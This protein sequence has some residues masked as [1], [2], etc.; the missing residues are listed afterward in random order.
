M[1]ATTIALCSALLAAPVAARAQ[2]STASTTPS[3]GAVDVG[4]QF[5]SVSGDE[6]RY[7]H[8]RDL[9]T[10]VL[11]DG[12]HFT[13]EKNDWRFKATAT[14]VGYRD[15]KYTGE[16][17]RAG[18][19]LIT[20]TWDQIPLFYGS[21]D[22]DQFGLL[23]ATP[24][25][26][27]S[28]GVSRLPDSLQAA[29][30]ATPSVLNSA[31]TSAALGVEMR[32]LRKTADFALV[33]HAT[34]STDLLFHLVNTMKDGQQ[35]WAATFGFSNAIELPG[36]LDHRT[37]D[38]TGQVQWS[39]ER[40]TIRAGYDGSFFSNNVQTLVWDN[41]L[42][43]TDISGGPSQGREPLWPDNSTNGVSATTAWKLGKRTRVFGNLSFSKWS[44]DGALLPYT[45]NTALPVFPLERQTA[46]VSADVTGVYAGLNSRPSDRSWLTV[47]YKLYDYDNR[48]PEFPVTDFVNYDTSVAAF[49]EGGTDTL[50]YKRQ[51]FDADY[52]YNIAPFTAL[53]AGYGL[54][55][56]KR[57]FR[58]FE[59]TKDQTFR[60]SLDTTGTTWLMLRA[61]YNYSKRTGTGLD[62]EVF[63][64]ENEGSA[65]PR[66][67]DIADRNRNRVAVIATVTPREQF[68]LNVSTGYVKDEYVN[69]AFGL[70]NQDGRFFSLGADYSPRKHVDVFADY[71]YEKYGT[72]QKS[73]QASPGTQEFDPTRDWTNDGSDHAHT[74]T[75]GV[76]LKR[77]NEKVDADWMLEY[78]NSADSYTY[79]LAPNQTIFVPPAALK[80]LPG[81][82]QDRTTSDLNVM[83]YISR[84]VGLGAGW[85]Y[86]KFN[87]DDWAWTQETLNGL[88][89][90]A[91]AGSHQIVLTRYMYRPYTGNTGFVRVRYLF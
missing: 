10:G 5:T 56:D 12:F 17:D 84:R 88:S 71:G 36:P 8:Y 89:L 68:S 28:P 74:F 34:S 51:Y 54:E 60:V 43:A 47:R 70:Q 49:A 33:Y 25:T 40:G 23:T 44:Q 81:F 37:T 4:A 59:N 7:Q 9:R 63:D 57:T 53:K 67:F 3:T 2:E 64:A 75:T 42:R 15:Q 16:I 85:L 26:V 31:I 66:Q 61:Q 79:G 87:S 20:F 22:S 18:K 80:Q 69:S 11:L 6:A 46:D 38:I 32:Q 41:P 27:E 78:S 86:E 39:N 72:L 76:S 1:R 62:E 65:L 90:P 73:R 14:H 50:S 82:S 35:P 45:I 29:V 13:Q 58:Q 21:V 19:L 30:Q 48:T 77:L 52:S 91:G 24:Y 83:Y 55:S